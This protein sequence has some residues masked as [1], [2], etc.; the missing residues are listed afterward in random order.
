MLS[1]GIQVLAYTAPSAGP[2]GGDA[3]APINTGP[4]PQ[5]KNGSLDLNG[6][7]FARDGAEIGIFTSTGTILN[8]WGGQAVIN[9]GNLRVPDAGAKGS[10]VIA[11]RYCFGSNNTEGAAPVNCITS[12]PS[13]GGAVS[14]T[15]GLGIKTTPSPITGTGSIAVDDAYVL[16]TTS[17][18][19]SK[20]GPL[21]VNFGSSAPVGLVV[22]K[23]SKTLGDVKVIDGSGLGWGVISPKFC[24]GSSSSFDITPTE[25]ITSWSEV[26]GPVIDTSQ[27]LDKSATTQTKTGVLK[28]GTSPGSGASDVSLVLDGRIRIEGGNPGLGKV[29]TAG[30]AGGDA[31]WQDTYIR[32]GIEQGESKTHNVT[33]SSAMPDNGYAVTITNET[34]ASNSNDCYKV[35]ITSK[36]TA[37]FTFQTPDICSVVPYNWIAVNF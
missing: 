6:Q 35:I 34:S 21:T 26:A 9:Q 32:S 3:Y 18:S 11:T 4:S 31:S 20:Q 22:G 16:N 7:I 28:L 37:G 14:L 27:F 2:T 10:A 33:F 19:Q 30:G 25:C 1:A 24:F 17:A 29:L 36:T 8:V 12:W 5:T 23:T 15:G 13:G